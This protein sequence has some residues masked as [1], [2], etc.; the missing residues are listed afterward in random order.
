MAVQ[1]ICNFTARL[2]RCIDSNVQRVL[3]AL[4]VQCPCPALM[5]FVFSFPVQKETISQLTASQ[6]QMNLGLVVA[7]QLEP[8]LAYVR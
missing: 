2:S 5:A 6:R 4:A 7:T 3:D 8:L 1:K